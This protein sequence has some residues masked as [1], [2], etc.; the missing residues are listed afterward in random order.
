[1]VLLIHPST[2]TAHRNRMEIGVCAESSCPGSAGA[3]RWGRE[4]PESPVSARRPQHRLS[5][6]SSGSCCGSPDSAGGPAGQGARVLPVSDLPTGLRA[7]HRAAKGPRAAVGPTAGPGPH[8]S[9]EGHTQRPGAARAGP[10]DHTDQ[11]GGKRRGCRRGRH[12]RAAPQPPDI[13]GGGGRRPFPRCPVRRACPRWRRCR[14]A[15]DPMGV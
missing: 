8:T 11:A 9:P 1:M 4:L 10:T 12:F 14:P 15:P 7:E 6:G 5:C 3:A 13:N 2:S